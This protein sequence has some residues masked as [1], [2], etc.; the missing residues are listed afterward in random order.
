MKCAALM[1]AMAMAGAV[2][3][4]RIELNL[5][6]MTSAYKLE[7]AI[8]RE[9]DLKY[10]QND[11]S[12]VKSRQDW[13]EKCPATLVPQAWKNGDASEGTV[14]CPFPVAA[15]YDH[16]D[17]TVAVTTRIYKVDVE[18]R[19][20]NHA[21]PGQATEVDQQVDQN[22]AV[23]SGEHECYLGSSANKVNFQYRSTYLFKYDAS[24]SAGNHAEQVVFALI[25][26]DTKAPEFTDTAGVDP[27]QH[28]LTVEAASD[29][30]MCELKASD[31]V[32][33][34]DCATGACTTVTN[35]KV[36]VTEKI[37]Y[38]IQHIHS[39][40]VVEVLPATARNVADAVQ[41]FQPHT[42]TGKHTCD[43][44]SDC[45]A[46]KLGK[47]LVTATVEDDAGIYG[48]NAAN[49]VATT[50]VAIQ[51][52]DTRPP[53]IQLKGHSPHYHEC[54]SNG[55]FSDAALKATYGY[56]DAGADAL[57]L[58]DT[59][60]RKQTTQD[61]E[62]GCTDCSEADIDGSVNVYTKA[63]V[64]DGTCDNSLVYR[65]DSTHTS[66]DLTS[67]LAHANYANQDVEGTTDVQTKFFNQLRQASFS[68]SAAN[69]AYTGPATDQT[70]TRTIQYDARDDRST[71][72]TNA[73]AGKNGNWAK[74]V[75]RQIITHDTIKPT[76]TLQAPPSASVY[77][78][79]TT[80][81]TTDTP[82]CHHS[83]KSTHDNHQNDA[84]GDAAINGLN[85]DPEDSVVV[86][87]LC[88]DT[89]VK[90]TRSWG[91][92]EYNARQLGH[93]VRTYTAIDR[94][95]NKAQIVRTI[96]VIDEESPVIVM[97]PSN[98]E[99]TTTLEA[100]RDSEYTDSGATCNDYVDG[101]LSHAVE[102]SGEVVNM[103]IPGTYIIR[104][105][106]TD[107][108][109]NAADARHRTVVIEDTQCPILSLLGEQTEYHEAGFPYVDMGATATDT[110]DGDI[111]Q[112]IWTDGNTVNH[113]QA[114]YTRRSCDE[115]KTAC[116][117]E[118]VSVGTQKMGAC[119][120]GDYYITTIRKPTKPTN[121][122]KNTY[123]RQ[124]VHCWM[125]PEKA[126]TFKIFQLHDCFNVHQELYGGIPEPMAC[127]KQDMCP[128]IGMKHNKN[129]SAGLK[130]YIHTTAKI[131]FKTLET[132]LDDVE[133]ANHLQSDSN[134]E[135]FG[136]S[137]YICM[138]VPV[139]E[140]LHGHN[141]ATWVGDYRETTEGQTGDYAITNSEQGKYV[142]QFHVSD[143]F[144][145]EECQ[146]ATKRTVVVKDTLPPVISL[147]LKGA[148]GK[149]LIH[150][151]DTTARGL[152]G[153]V[154]PAGPFNARFSNNPFLKTADG[155][156][157][158]SGAES[159][160]TLST[161]TPFTSSSLMAETTNSN[162]WIIGAVASA[163]AGVALL[164]F[165]QRKTTVSVPV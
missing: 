135:W 126:V 147:A 152:D 41:Y 69:Q 123:H 37:S 78:A 88:D 47:F 19:V 16:Q 58:L 102:V 63:C 155:A 129:P 71:E 80:C 17:Q 143:K 66:E 68:W 160:Y 154:N 53:V 4:P 120:N 35:N 104:Y 13:T 89:D 48:H 1:S 14:S 164:G 128:D 70:K 151:S 96:N 7:T 18:G 3:P 91:P 55:K 163:V 136:D 86:D 87:D 27:C 75:S 62:A 165:S 124:L 5:E 72:G 32:R 95:Q 22:T 6:G 159:S 49:N 40:Q 141:S 162:A 15:G 114:F 133:D 60:A 117:E 42:Q 122:G 52:A 45:G 82:L 140:N 39:G 10:S 144:G 131:D 34:E 20:C 57:D 59:W 109:G 54:V 11:G 30:R 21:K 115:I 101:E 44:S 139:H 23:A 92:R 26:D 103:R 161:A 84:T 74:S 146:P 142:I 33:N 121:V 125:T 106:C 28:A 112:Y 108:S 25:L 134:G 56:K 138:E 132:D 8:E 29:W 98:T 158:V 105:D 130:A 51:V 107:L 118:D 77:E 46:T 149:K 2:A 145:N 100:T 119:G 83:V 94:R 97:V 156:T 67:G 90:I 110:L 148:G 150:F 113:K 157:L 36:D 93:Y 73:P 127:H 81:G 85:I 64:L 24:D 99:T 38:Q 9:H 65:F 76:L 116:S 153:Q 31:N 79:S 12:V 50:H 137:T 61:Y 111:T 43:D